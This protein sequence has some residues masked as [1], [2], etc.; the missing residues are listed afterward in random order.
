MIF[1]T[2]EIAEN[3]GICIFAISDNFCNFLY[4]GWLCHPHRI[5]NG[6]LGMAFLKG[7]RTRCPTAFLQRNPRPRGADQIVS[8]NVSDTMAQPPPAWG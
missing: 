7:Y 6:L 5:R 3:I 4:N 2:L 1:V 8:D